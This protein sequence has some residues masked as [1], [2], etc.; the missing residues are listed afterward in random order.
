[1]SEMASSDAVLLGVAGLG[2]YGRVISDLIL[3]H[4][5]NLPTPARLVA[6]CDPA[7]D[8]HAQRAATLQDRGVTVLDSYKKMLE[9]PGL[10][11]V[12]L[13]LP[14]QLHRAF[15]EQA[16]AAGKGVVIEKPAAGTVDEVDAMIAARDRAGLPVIIGFQDVYDA[17]TLPLKRRILAGEF[18]RITR[19]SL[20]AC[21]P[22]TDTYFNRNNWAGRQR[23]GDTWVLDSP[24]N[25]ALAH[26]VNLVQFLLGPSIQTS[27]APLAVEAELYRAAPIENYDTVSARVTLQGQVDFLIL[28]THASETSLH[29]KIV[30]HGERGRITREIT[31]IIIET[32][33]NTETI[34]LHR[35]KHVD[36]LHCFTRLLRGETPPVAGPGGEIA[37]ATLE[38]ARNHTLLINGISE[39]APIVTVPGNAVRTAAGHDGLVEAIVG[40]EDAF[41][42]CAEHNQLLHASG[43]LPFTQAAG[44][45]DLR[46]YRRF[47]GPKQA[48]NETAAVAPR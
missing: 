22:R 18:G 28:L 7:A 13:P 17:T 31:R 4:G 14:I 9:T 24:A 25:N 42:H 40:I 2:G 27:A 47:S 16:L 8:L 39:A 21:W 1:M 20:H 26:P 48:A 12:W 44:S 10:D 23:A 41:S 35:P 34:E 29:P 30:L 5:P 46:N 37:A 19:A 15:A 32:D 33:G 38:V 11:A 3:D 43:R 36:M 6:V 45:K